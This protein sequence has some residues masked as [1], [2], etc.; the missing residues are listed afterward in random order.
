MT[1]HQPARK[2]NF[3]KPTKICSL[4]KKKKKKKWK[5][6]NLIKSGIEKKKKDIFF[7]T[8]KRETLKRRKKLSFTLLIKRNNINHL[9]LEV[10]YNSYDNRKT[11]YKKKTLYFS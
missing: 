9:V 11:V 1:V 8:C 3:S 10:D 2:G 4:K 7:L 5:E 6:R